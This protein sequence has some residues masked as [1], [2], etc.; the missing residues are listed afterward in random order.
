MGEGMLFVG[1]LDANVVALDMKTGREVWRTAIEDWRNGYSIASA[2]LYYDGIVYS[3]ISGGELGIRGRL[4][5][6]DA[7]TGKILWRF[8][9][10]PAPG[11]YGSDTWPAPSGSIIPRGA[12]IWNTP[13]LDPQLGLIYFATGNCGPDY[14][15]S[16]R[17]GDNLFCASIMALNAKTGQYAWHFQEVHHDIWDYDSASPVVLFD[18][19]IDGQ[20]RKGIAEAGKT[21]WV[22][23][24]DRTNG[25]PLIGIDERPVP[26]DPRQKT[27]K[28]QPYPRGDAT[29]P[30]CADP[31][32]DLKTGCIFTP[33]WDEPVALQPSG[34]GGTN[35][36]PMPYSPDTGYFYVP[37][38]IR[39]S[40]FERFPRQYRPGSIYT[41]GAQEAAFH[42]PLA[43]T[44]TAI[45]S[46]TN[47][48]A[49]QHKLPYRMGGG[50]GSSVT[51]SGLL[52]RGE[53]DGNFVAVDAVTGKV[54][55]KFQTGF[56]ADAPPI[57]YEVD[58]EQ[59]IAIATGGNSIQ[60]SATGD[61]VWSFSLKGTVGPAW[62][63]PTPPP[64]GLGLGLYWRI[65]SALSFLWPDNRQS[66]HLEEPR[67]SGAQGDRGDR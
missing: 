1:Q 32:P 29:V 23:I 46:K 56:G 67:G 40:V 9:T 6:L 37:G 60:R 10:V 24:L 14:D 12:P 48:I 15:G 34:Q 50:S 38:S 13:A 52:F 33:F 8:Y 20:T 25:K 18:T 22:Y 51:A 58:G 7:K 66:G 45:D 27:A 21:G 54:L 19:V 47:Q 43:G 17:E 64:T 57:I 3:G 62:W 41:S 36:S 5:A 55:W 53:P 35:W 39:T 30:Q 49:W 16:V 59:Y 2:P 31:Q 42:T 61:A 44:F 4:T 63:P 26:Q 65:R 11:E 28:T